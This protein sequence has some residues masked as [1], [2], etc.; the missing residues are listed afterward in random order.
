MGV[1]TRGIIDMSLLANTP[2]Y[3]V[4]GYP[5]LPTYILLMYGQVPGW[6]AVYGIY[7]HPHGCHYPYDNNQPS[8]GVTYLQ[9]V[10]RLCAA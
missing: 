5:M 4:L 3:K 2:T 7:A 1:L 8:V 6:L 9:P 10:V